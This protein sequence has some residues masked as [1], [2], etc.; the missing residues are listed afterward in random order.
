MYKLSTKAK[1]LLLAVV[2]AVLL[3]AL[4]GTGIYSMRHMS[5]EIQDDLDAAKIERTALIAI[6]GAHSH[7]KTQVQEWKNILIRGGDT[8][9][10]D[11]Y[12]AQFTAEEKEVQALLTTAMAA[13]KERGIATSDIDQL[14]ADHRE[15]GGKYREALKFYFPEDKA[16]AQAV[17]RLVKGMDRATGAGMEK[18]RC[19]CRAIVG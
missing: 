2:T 12:L 14:L 8:A 16:A 17:D 15:M 3:A 7:F 9:A 4:G 13:M 18:D 6:E 19:A 11:T 1:L 10:F 5:G